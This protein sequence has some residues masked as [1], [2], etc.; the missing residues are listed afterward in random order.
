MELIQNHDAIWDLHIHTC[1]CPK[2]TGEF[3][4]FKT[5]D[6]IRQIIQIFENTIDFELFSFTDHNQISIEVYEEYI[7]QNGRTEFLV[8]VE[9][10]VFLN[11][12][13]KGNIKH[14]I[15]YF[16]IEKSDFNSKITFLKEYN[17]FVNKNA[18]YIYDLLEFLAHKKIEFV[19]SPHAFKQDRRGIEYNW[20]SEIKVKENAPLFTDQFF[21]FRES[22]GISQIRRAIQF[23]EEF[24]LKGEISVISFSDSSGF[25]KLQNYLKKPC[26]FFSSLPCFKGLELVSAD[27]SRIN[28]GQKRESDRNNFGNLIGRVEFMNNTIAF[29]DR[30]NCIIGG[31]GSGKSL[32]LDAMA[33]KMNKLIP[34]NKNKSRLN[35]IKKWPI[36]IYNYS[37]NEIKFDN[38]ECEYFMQ[39]YATDLFNTADYCKNIQTFFK[40]DFAKIC[41]IDEALIKESNIE[42]FSKKLINFDTISS[43]E[44]ISNFLNKYIIISDNAFNV[45]FNEEIKDV[46]LLK[47]I[48]KITFY[49]K[50]S[51]LIPET[52][53]NNAKINGS[54]EDLYKIVSQE[55]HLYNMHLVDT[56]LIK[57]ITQD[58]YKEYENDYSIARKEKNIAENLFKEKFESKGNLHKMRVNLINCYF[59]VE[60][61]F[62]SEYTCELKAC[63]EKADSFLLKK[64]LKIER[65]LEYLRRIFKD[66]FNLKSIKNNND[67]DID[68][69]KAVLIYCF[70]DDF[71]LKEGKK[72]ED[73]DNRLKL[74]D[75][76]YTN[77]VKIFYKFNST[78]EDILSLSPGQQT[79]ILMEYLIYKNTNVPLLIDQPEDNID[80][81]TI[82]N[83]VTNWFRTLKSKRQVILVTHDANIVI[84][85]DAE[86]L[87]IANHLSNNTF[88]YSYGALEYK[89]NLENASKILD[90]GVEAVKRRLNKYGE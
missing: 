71:Q 40:E 82:Y 26:Q 2:S 39:S 28:F 53:R 22:S 42:N 76:E 29:S 83:K 32:L 19:L 31:R 9:Q 34:D 62:Q 3:K 84:N 77:D 55:I 61:K 47:Y 41:D 90:G 56:S 17:S 51:A 24:D 70:C 79:N 27:N 66:F 48:E 60:R 16:D 85:G 86:N 21:C 68:L 14:L 88:E 33:Y 52:L 4:K 18:V 81:L 73:L 30:L 35:F 63:G 58:S 37:G 89:D 36:K 80:H 43:Q 65:P 7:R 54:I 10:D 23:L 25:S 15:I 74:F 57:K 38:F 87:I 50:I 59:D 78:Y 75:L 5:A 13:N 11:K 6:F 67:A 8:G 45:S 1:C 72:I 12:E 49:K 44:N 20:S 46:V 69:K 64:V